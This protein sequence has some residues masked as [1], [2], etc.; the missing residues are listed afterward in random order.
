MPV[1]RYTQG[2]AQ[3]GTAHR[4]GGRASLL[5]RQ[6]EGKVRVLLTEPHW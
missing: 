2:W 3:C 6:R 5:V 1:H 4:R